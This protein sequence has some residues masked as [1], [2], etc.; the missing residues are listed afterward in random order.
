MVD[1]KQH[2]DPRPRP[3]PAHRSW[4]GSVPGAAEIGTSVVELARR[5]LVGGN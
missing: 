3:R 2:L 4:E 1:P 5:A